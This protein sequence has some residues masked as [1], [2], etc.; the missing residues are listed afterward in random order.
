MTVDLLE[1]Q[2]EELVLQENPY[3]WILFPIKYTRLWNLYKKYEVAFWTAEL[4]PIYD[5]KKSITKINRK[6]L[7]YMELLFSSRIYIHNT[8]LDTVILSCE[9][10]EQVQV[11]EA[12]GYFSFSMCM[13]NIYKEF[14]MNYNEIIRQNNE[15]SDENGERQDKL[16]YDKE[17]ENKINNNEHFKKTKEFIGA[18]L[19]KNTLF[20]EKLIY[21]SILK[22]IFSCGLHLIRFS[23]SINN[24]S[25]DTLAQLCEGLDRIRRDEQYQVEFCLNIAKSMKTKPSNE[26]MITLLEEA[27]TIEKDFIFSIIDPDTIGIERED[28]VAY[29]LYSADEILTDLKYPRQFNVSNPFANIFND[30]PAPSQ[31]EAIARQTLTQ[32]LKAAHYRTYQEISNS[33]QFSTSQDF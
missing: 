4:I 29:L 28:I 3:R 8:S 7:N 11:P 20:S 18:F 13:E 2:K 27:V 1:Q 22:K 33:N 31:E 9:L 19:D 12:R 6:L 5:D 25:G 30:L 23:F 32:T 26:K 24:E 15:K 17:L 14:L 10:L 16:T 21:Y